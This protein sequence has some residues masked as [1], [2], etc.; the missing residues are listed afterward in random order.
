M[1]RFLVVLLLVVVVGGG[2]LGLLFMGKYNGLVS[3]QETVSARWGEVDNMYK[4]RF[5]LIQQLVDTVRG[6]ADFERNTLEAV[7][8][9][10]ASVGQVQ[11]PAEM[12]TDPEALAAYMQAQQGLSGALGRLFALSENYPQLRATES[13]LSLQDQIEGSENRITVARS[14]FIEAV[15]L[16]NTSLRTFPSNLLAGLFGFEKA[17][18][19]PA[20]PA[21]HNAPVID[22]RQGG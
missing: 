1:K 12:P 16:Y 17:A 8:Q 20:E 11:L 15:R 13:F 6:A 3:G 4:R 18:T 9:A 5:D 14:D 7:I 19:L 2:L 10:R 22:F 21:T